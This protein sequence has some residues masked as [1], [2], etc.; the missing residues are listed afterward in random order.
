MSELYE[1]VQQIIRDDSD[2]GMDQKQEEHEMKKEKDSLGL[3]DKNG[4][5]NRRE[6]LK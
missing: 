6:L 5:N 4:G 3:N 2:Y 1:E